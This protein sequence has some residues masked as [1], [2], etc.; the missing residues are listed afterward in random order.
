MHAST[1]WL[2]PGG[3]SQPTGVSKEHHHPSTHQIEP[4]R[5]SRESSF[6]GNVRD[7]LSSGRRA[8]VRGRSSRENKRRDSADR[9]GGSDRT[10]F[11]PTCVLTGIPGIGKSELALEF[12]YRHSQ[13]YRRVLWVG[14]ECRYLRQNY[15]NQANLLG[16]DVG[17]ETTTK[18]G[19]RARVRT[20]EEHEA[21]ALHKVRH[22]LERD[23]PYLLII[24]NLDAERDLWDGRDLSEIL[25]R[26]GSATHVVITTSLRR[27][28]HLESLEVPY[29][30][31]FEALTLMHNG[32]R[33]ERSFS[34]RQIDK[35]KEIEDKLGRLPFGLVIVGK[36]INEFNMKPSEILVKMGTIETVN[37][38][39]RNSFSSST[40]MERDTL[41]DI[42]LRSNPFLVKLLDVCFSLMCGG[43]GAKSCLAV[44]MAY[45]GGWFAPAP[46][47]LSLLA[48]AAR[49]LQKEL[50]SLQMRTHF[51]T[52]MLGCWMPTY[53]HGRT[54]AEASALLTRLGLARASTRK[55]CLYFPDIIQVSHFNQMMPINCVT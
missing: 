25:P 51:I 23:L 36:L 3:S 17:M 27:V 26:L 5:R 45:V 18:V 37:L 9:R 13:K 33:S 22:E 30:S 53:K 47:P 48:L 50:G 14:G 2:Y 32:K 20:F 19:G 55:D 52:S 28:M 54:E 49:K 40:S 12:A 1:A 6:S 44:R 34:V 21:D 43:T 29:L 42:V 16:V 11:A 4:D 7:P 31:S 8:G 39:P 15:L 10:R 38:K 35:F 24:D 46:F 41:D